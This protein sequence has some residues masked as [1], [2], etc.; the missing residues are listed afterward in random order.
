MRPV[1]SEVGCTVEAL[2]RS[3]RQAA[4]DQG[5]RTGMTTDERQRLNDLEREDLKLKARERD[6]AKA[7]ADLAQ[8]ELDRRAK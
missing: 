2:H 5:K 3:V 6:S 1:A 4:R 8:A 7:S